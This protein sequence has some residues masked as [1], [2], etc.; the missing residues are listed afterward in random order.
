MGHI[1]RHAAQGCALC[2]RGELD[3]PKMAFTINMIPSRIMGTP[4]IA[5]MMVIESTTPRI[6][7][8]KPRIAPTSL[9]VN[10]KIYKTS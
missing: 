1:K 2:F 7:I 3:Q 6:A 4:I 10:F 8:T 9:P 5:P